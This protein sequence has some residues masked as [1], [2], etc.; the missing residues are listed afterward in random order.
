M[1]PLI[2]L[3]PQWRRSLPQWTQRDLVNRLFIRFKTTQKAGRGGKEKASSASSTPPKTEGSSFLGGTI[4]QMS[5]ATYAKT[6]LRRGPPERVLIYNGGAGKIVMLGTL[7][8]TTIFIFGAACLFLAP[9]FATADHPWYMAPAIIVCGSIPMLFVGYTAVP[10]VN[11]IHLSLPMTARRSREQM[12]RYAKNLPP[13]AILHIN[14]MRF[15]TYP[16][17]ADVKLADL[18]PDSDL[19]RPVSFR[20]VNPA[21]YQWW[22]GKPT[23]QF[24]TSK[25]SK[26]EKHSS[27]FYPELWEPVFKQIL[28]NSKK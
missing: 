21:P 27:A 28:A 15:T 10:F 20:N 4:T 26:M 11:Y 9:A 25:E 12:L 17:R 22:Q 1:R 6:T 18:V 3:H 24:Y 13:D 14:T 2:L 5:P 23:S 16:R 7:R 19:L 8:I